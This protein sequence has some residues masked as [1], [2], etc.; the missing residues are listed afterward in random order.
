MKTKITL[1]TIFIAG[2]FFIARAQAPAI[3]WQN[4]TGG[5]KMDYFNGADQLPDGGFVASGDGESNDFDL[6]G[7]SQWGVQEGWVKVVNSN[8]TLRHQK[9]FGGSGG[10]QLPSV[11]R[12]FDGG[13]ACCGPSASGDHDLPGNYGSNDYWVIR[14]DSLL[15][16]VWSKHFGGSGDD[17]CYIIKQ[18]SDSGFAISG[19]SNSLDHDVTGN[20][21]TFDWWVIKLDKNGILQWERAIGGSG[22]DNFPAA[23]MQ[24]SDGGYLVGG[25]SNSN[26]SGDIGASH[27]GYDAVLAKLNANGT[28]AWTKN[29]GGA[30]DE[31]VR[32]VCQTPDGGFVF[33]GSTTSV[34]GDVSGN[35]GLNDYWVVKT[36]SAGNLQWQ[37]CCGGTRNDFA[38]NIALTTEGGYVVCGRAFSYDGEITGHQPAASTF[39]DSADCWVAKINAFNPTGALDWEIAFGGSHYDGANWILQSADHGFLVAGEVYSSDGNVTNFHGSSAFEDGWLVKLAPDPVLSSNEIFPNESN[40]VAYPNPF[41]DQFNIQLNTINNES[42]T[43]SVYNAIG[44]LVLCINSPA[45]EVIGIGRSDLPAAGLYFYTVTNKNLIIA[46]GKMMAE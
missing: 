46:R 30:G 29:Y 14:M 21:G 28:V 43:V 6:T 34:S 39:V 3:L 38:L 37:R 31:G 41:H 8:G 20:H 40:V 22:I 45:N 15:N 5:T 9:T 13:Y 11:V 18:T 25:N 7:D 36:D 32:S 1:S 19:R 44:E 42:N 26:N 27:G 33:C 35:H 2:I 4:C 24:T 23:L 17:W 12:T 16:I 10:D